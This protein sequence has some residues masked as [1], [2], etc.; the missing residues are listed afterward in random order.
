VNLVLRALVGFLGSMKLAVVLLVLIGLLTWF[1]TLAQV[2]KGL[3]EVQKEYFE[4]WYVLCQLPLSIGG[5]ALLPLDNGKPF[6]LT[7]PLPGA[8]PVMILLFFNLLV[9]GI[10]RVRWQLRNIGVLIAHL[11]IC[12]LLFAGFV[13]LHY[14]DAGYLSLYEPPP[15]GATAGDRQTMSSV[16]VSHTE[17]ELALLQ[18]AGDA[19][20]E[21]P[22]PESVVAAARDGATV[23]LPA[24]GLP[25]RVE[26]HGFADNAEPRGKGPMFDA[27]APVIDGVYLQPLPLATERERNVAG[28]YVTVLGD[29]GTRQQGILSG[30]ESRPWSR[31]RAP[32]TFTVQGQRF[33]LDLRRVT[34]QLPFAVALDEFR[35]TDHP[36]TMMAADFRSFVTVHEGSGENA[37]TQ[38]VQIYMNHPLRKDG[39][40]LFQTNWGPQE[41]RRPPF[42]SV[43]EVARNPSDQWPNYACWVI[44]IGMLVHFVLRLFRFLGA[45]PREA[46]S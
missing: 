34:R 5:Q 42:Y 3:F 16:Y 43:F 27:P 26:V 44:A 32:F 29:D 45:S 37:R 21:R 15:E 23:V 20:V 41:T 46:T 10:A 39:Y 6:A 36:G 8:Y 7:I 33:G 9:G 11:G 17:Y 25:F 2:H 40:V 19:I 12:L 24:K 14:S 35:K 4:S 38:Q 28:C 1:G 30:E 31:F 13:T 18:D 22:V